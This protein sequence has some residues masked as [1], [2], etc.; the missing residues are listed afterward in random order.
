MNVLFSNSPPVSLH[1]FYMWRHTSGLDAQVNKTSIK[2]QSL[3]CSIQQIKH[4]FQFHLKT[5]FSFKS[6]KKLLT[7]G[8][9]WKK[10]N[11]FTDTAAF[12]DTFDCNF[13][14]NWRQFFFSI[15]NQNFI[16]NFSLNFSDYFYIIDI[17]H[18]SLD[19]TV[20][21]NIFYKIEPICFLFA[22]IKYISLRRVF[23]YQ[24]SHYYNLVMQIL[25]LISWLCL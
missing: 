10:K 7:N 14:V 2:M 6:Q 23:L 22:D 8:S 19:K 20:L 1:H 25:I 24:K 17:G 4:L 18:T 21:V 11:S 13:D 12:S 9:F 15:L 3:F 16:P 5:A